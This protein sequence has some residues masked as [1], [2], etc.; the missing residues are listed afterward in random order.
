MT[1]PPIITLRREQLSRAV[2]HLDGEDLRVLVAILVAATG[3]GHALIPPARLAEVVRIDPGD[4]EAAL[5]R[6]AEADLLEL[7]P[8]GVLDVRGVELGPLFVRDREAPDHLPFE[9]V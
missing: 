7:L 1:Y 8:H 5:R 3:D 2:R 9:S 4:V 6:L